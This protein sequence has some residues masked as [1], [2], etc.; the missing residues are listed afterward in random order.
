[1]RS[2]DERDEEEEEEVV[3]GGGGSVRVSGV[4]IVCKCKVLRS[5]C[6]NGAAVT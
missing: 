6:R 5:D 2:D 3:G 4:G 1:L